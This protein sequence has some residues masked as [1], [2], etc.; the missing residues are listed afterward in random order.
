MLDLWSRIKQRQQQL[1]VK[2]DGRKNSWKWRDQPTEC[3]QK[4]KAALAAGWTTRWQEGPDTG[5]E[6]HNP[7]RISLV[8][9]FCLVQQETRLA[10]DPQGPG[11]DSLLYGELKSEHPKKTSWN[12]PETVLAKTWRELHVCVHLCVL[13]LPP[14]EKLAWSPCFGQCLVG[15]RSR[16]FLCSS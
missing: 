1:R 14:S 10:H 2:G 13:L 4:E 6:G 16:V 12:S 8:K 9:V 7:A 3:S 5:L 11:L 15:G